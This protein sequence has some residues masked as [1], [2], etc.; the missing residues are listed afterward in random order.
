MAK[1]IVS[2]VTLGGT[3]YVAGQETALEALLTAAQVAHLLAAGAITG[4][5]TPGDTTSNNTHKKISAASTNATLV[6]AGAGK[7]F[8]LV[9][10]NTNAAARYLKLYDKLTAATIGTDVPVW[11]LMIPPG[12]GLALSIPD[13]LPFELGVGYGLTTGVADNDTGAVAAAEMIVN[14]RFE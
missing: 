6:K 12:A 1:A 10:S 13:G 14:L 7:I 8:A 3:T 4:D 2:G 5:W 11:T 9:C